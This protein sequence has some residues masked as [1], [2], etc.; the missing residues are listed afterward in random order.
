MTH[1]GG[2]HKNGKI[3]QVQKV[4]WK[5]TGDDVNNVVLLSL[6]DDIDDDDNDVYENGDVKEFQRKLLESKI[7]PVVDNTFPVYHS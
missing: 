4:S 6:N 7:F 1:N 3:D 2:S 5:W